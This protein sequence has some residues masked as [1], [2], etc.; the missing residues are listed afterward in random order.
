MTIIISLYDYLSE[1]LG[2][3]ETLRRGESL[4]ESADINYIAIQANDGTI[5]NNINDRDIIIIQHIDGTRAAYKSPPRARTAINKLRG[6]VLTEIDAVIYTPFVTPQA[7]KDNKDTRE[8]GISLSLGM[9]D[10]KTDGAQALAA[11]LV[12][13]I[14]PRHAGAR[15]AK[16]RPRSTWLSYYQYPSPT[17]A[18]R[19]LG[20]AVRDLAAFCTIY[21]WNAVI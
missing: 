10:D 3:F 20:Y 8:H 5:A 2:Y 12:R 16:W 9:G 7:S 14:S 19:C 1:V 15:V 17:A 6:R 11:A 4:P 18:R 21:T 13:P